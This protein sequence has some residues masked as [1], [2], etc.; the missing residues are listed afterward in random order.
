MNKLLLHAS[1]L[2]LVG[3]AFAVPAQADTLFYHGHSGLNEGHTQ[4][5]ALYAQNQC[6][7]DFVFNSDPLLPDLGGYNLVFISV[8]GF[9]NPNAF[10]SDAEKTAIT[11]WLQSTQHRIVLIG[12]WD[13]FYGEGQQVLIDLINDIG[14][15]GMA[16]IPGSF[17]SGCSAYSCDGTLGVDPLVTGLDH[18]CKAA[19]AVWNEGGGAAVAWPFENGSDPWVISNGTNIPCIVGI[20]DSNTLSDGCNHLADG[21]TAAFALRLCT[22]NC[23]GVVPVDTSTWGGIKAVYR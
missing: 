5:A 12:E 21:D 6:G 13:G 15:G 18:V 7:G 8:P 3:G 22:I 2:L 10:F 11:T 17:D 1:A 19:T 16:F 14:V 23:E 4:L 9:S 20:G